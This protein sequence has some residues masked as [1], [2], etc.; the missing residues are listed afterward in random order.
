MMNIGH[1]SRAT[2]TGISRSLHDE[3]QAQQWLQSPEPHH[4]YFDGGGWARTTYLRIMRPASPL[5]PAKATVRPRRRAS[6]SDPH[7]G[8]DSERCATVRF[9]KA[10]YSAVEPAGCVAQ[11]SFVRVFSQTACA[12]S[13]ETSSRSASD[14][15]ER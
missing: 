5:G 12:N 13:L 10:L 9:R 11:L 14:W 2:F 1:F 6:A 15:C 4:Q 8:T 3:S 7:F